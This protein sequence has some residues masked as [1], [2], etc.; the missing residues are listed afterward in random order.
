MPTVKDVI[1]RKPTEAEIKQCSNWPIW[2]CDVS[3]FD[4]DYTQKEVC[5][6]LEGKVTV[7]DRGGDGAVSFGPGDIVI[8]P[9]DLKC[10][11]QV[12]EAVKKHY[13]FE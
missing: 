6:I 9:K 12:T 7:K 2:T 3:A 11:W 8:F 1:V 13:N 4:W 5:L 10:T